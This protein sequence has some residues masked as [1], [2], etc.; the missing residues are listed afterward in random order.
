MHRSTLIFFCLTLACSFVKG[1]SVFNGR[2]LEFKTRIALRGV[3]VENLNNNLKGITAGDGSFNIGARVGDLIVFRAFAYKP[4]TLLL[5]TMYSREVF[6]T[7]QTNVLNEVR[8]TDSSGRTSVAE[9]NTKL[10]F[11]PQF[12]GQTVYAHRDK[13]GLFDGGATIRMH[14]FTKD[15]RDKR[16][17][18]QR[19]SDLRKAEEIERIYVASNIEKFVPLKG[20]DMDNF[21]LLYT[22]DVKTY[23]ATTYDLTG[24]LNMCYKEWQTLTPDQKKAGQIFK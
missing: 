21:L 20:V 18:N 13:D 23:T 5:T 19:A 9:K 7:P 4:D 17:A 3:R 12:H 11:D 16:K 8:I 14:Y 2:V 15:D 22:P 6:M 24:Y 10:A 1:Q